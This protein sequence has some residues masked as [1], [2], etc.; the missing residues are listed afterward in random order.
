MRNAELRLCGCFISHITISHC[1][2]QRF[3]QRMHK[4]LQ[5][6]HFGILLLWPEREDRWQSAIRYHY[7][8]IWVAFEGCK[9]IR[10]EGGYACRRLLTSVILHD[11]IHPSTPRYWKGSSEY[12]GP[13][14]C[15]LSINM[16]EFFGRFLCV[17][18]DS[19]WTDPHSGAPQLFFFFPSAAQSQKELRG[20][21]SRQQCQQ[22]KKRRER[23]KRLEVLI[24]DHPEL[25]RPIKRTQLATT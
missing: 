4:K 16:S 20:R 17:L 2:G 15:R 9:W 14:N 11:Y 7:T 6:V 8:Y 10:R 19:L 21:F 3:Q 13:F 22:Q 1:S 12:R 5:I 25:R 24:T 18:C 23:K